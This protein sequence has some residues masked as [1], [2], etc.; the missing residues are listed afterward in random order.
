MARDCSPATT[1][2]WYIGRQFSELIAAPKEIH[3]NAL[4]LFLDLQ[5]Q[6]HDLRFY[7]V[8]PGS[9]Q[10]LSGYRRRAFQKSCL[11]C[12]ISLLFRTHPPQN[13]PLS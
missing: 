1:Y 13:L 9:V 7:D 10:I 11:C 6:P 3:F 2:D 8:S 5:F 12:M 4:F